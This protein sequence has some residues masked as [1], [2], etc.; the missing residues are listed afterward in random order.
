MIKKRESE[1]INTADFATFLKAAS[2]MSSKVKESIDNGSNGIAC[3]KKGISVTSAIDKKLKQKTKL[4]WTLRA[5]KALDIDS[6]GYL[7]KHEILD[8]IIKVGAV[9]HMQLADIVK[10]LNAKHIHDHIEFEEFEEL[11]CGHSFIKRVLE[12]NLIVP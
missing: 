9:S 1:H 11:L 6:R 7:F 8:H 2:G 3:L 4:P 10:K 5:F 12:R